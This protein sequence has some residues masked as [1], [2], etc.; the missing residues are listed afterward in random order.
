MKS[1]G[2]ESRGGRS[3]PGGCETLRGVGEAEVGLVSIPKD[4]V[5]QFP[6]RHRGDQ[7]DPRGAQLVGKHRNPGLEIPCLSNHRPILCPVRGDSNRRWEMRDQTRRGFS[8]GR[9]SKGLTRGSLWGGDGK[10]SAQIPF[11]AAGRKRLRRRWHLGGR[12]GCEDALPVPALSKNSFSF[13]PRL[14]SPCT[15]RPEHPPH[16]RGR[17]NFKKKEEKR[18]FGAAFQSREGTDAVCPKTKEQKIPKFVYGEIKTPLQF[19]PLPFKWQKPRAGGMQPLGARG[20]TWHCPIS[21][22]LV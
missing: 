20:A 21:W 8:C 5:P 6:C 11:C 17:K 7:R 15:R 12:A 1:R 4:L 3:F 22:G 10:G 16:K 14:L 19:P 18:D 2:W 9:A 13:L